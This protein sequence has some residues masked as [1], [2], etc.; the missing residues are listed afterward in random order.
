[1]QCSFVIFKRLFEGKLLNQMLYIYDLSNIENSQTAKQQKFNMKLKG[2]CG[3]VAFFNLCVVNIRAATM[4][5]KVFCM[6][7]LMKITNF[8]VLK[9]NNWNSFTNIIFKINFN[10]KFGCNLTLQLTIERWYA[11]LS[12]AMHIT[13]QTTLQYLYIIIISELCALYMT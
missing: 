5:L 9:L 12:C 6:P 8:Q 13:Y 4:Y 2:K 7:L 11:S 1:M 10:Y 3:R